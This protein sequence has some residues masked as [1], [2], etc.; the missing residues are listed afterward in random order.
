MDVRVQI[1]GLSN[2]MPLTSAMFIRILLIAFIN[3]LKWAARTPIEWFQPEKGFNKMGMSQ[4]EFYDAGFV[5]NG[6]V[7]MCPERSL[8]A[9]KNQKIINLNLSQ[10]DNESDSE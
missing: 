3:P 9:D 4:V 10:G 5:R 1:Q 6:C 7:H 8:S 2:R